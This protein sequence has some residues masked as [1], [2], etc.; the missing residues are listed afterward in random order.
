MLTLGP[1]GFLMFTLPVSAHAAAGA[2]DPAAG[3]A[4]TEVELP[5]LPGSLPLA[6][7]FQEDSWD[8]LE[9]ILPA[10]IE[11][12]HLVANP[13]AIAAVHVIDAFPIHGL[14]EIWFVLVRVDSRVGMAETLNMAFTRVE[15]DRAD[16]LLMPLSAAAFARM[17][18]QDAGILCH[19]LAVPECDKAILGAI[20]NGEVH[21]AGD[22]EIAAFRL[23]G[24]GADEASEGSLEPIHVQRSQRRNISVTFGESYMLKTFRRVEEGLNPDFEIG[25][26]LTNRPDYDGTAPVLGAIEYHRRGR[27]PATLAVLRQYVPN[28][29][30]AWQLTLDFLSAFFERVAAQPRVRPPQPPAPVPILGAVEEMAASDPKDDWEEMLEGYRAT[31]QQ[32]GQ[33]TAALHLALAADPVNPGFAPEP[34]GRL[35]QRSIYQSLRNLTGRLC[36]RLSRERSALAEPDQKL[37]DQLVSQ[38]DA[39][40]DRFRKILDPEINGWRTRCHG[41]YHLGQLLFTGKNFSIIDFEGEAHRAIGERRLKRSPLRDVATMVRSL[42]YAVQSVLL[43]LATHRGQPPGI[44]RSED[45]QALAPWGFTWYNLAARDFVAEYMRTI[46]PAGLLPTTDAA[47]STLLEVLLL[48]QALFEIDFEL[49]E[50]PEWVGVPLRGAIRLLGNDPDDPALY[51]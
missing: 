22:R 3:E 10:Y 33:K 25:R 32:L 43:G 12:R 8:D 50:R 35:Y 21:R 18:G 45:Q 41:D 37:A 44:I 29:G 13:K 11:R 48:E 7:R 46:R 24:R 14:V 27:E 6:E 34:F 9:A 49:S 40:L 16:Q 17:R 28:Q 36:D 31:A 39:I 42:D 5:V 26:Y 20:L 1:H 4:A 23:E 2:F 38:R 47:C 15:E 19:A 51:L 30:T